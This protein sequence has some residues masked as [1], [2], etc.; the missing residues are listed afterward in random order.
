ML[1]VVR[2]SS[3]E[4]RSETRLIVSCTRLPKTSPCE[5]RLAA[6][7]SA[8]ASP[9]ITPVVCSWQDFV[10]ETIVTGPSGMANYRVQ[11]LV[12]GV[13]IIVP[14]ALECITSYVLYEQEDWFEDEIKFV[15][16]L[17]TYGE[18]VIDIGANFGVYTLAM[19]K[20]VGSSGAVWAFEP[21]SDVAD[22]LEQS[23]ALNDFR[24]AKVVRCAVSSSTGVAQFSTS[25]H[26]ELNAIV[27]RDSIEAAGIGRTDTVQTI[28]LDD[29]LDRFGWRDISFLKIDG[30]HRDTD[31][32]T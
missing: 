21:A 29:A 32:P 13:K 6:A 2:V 26:S 19:A 14:D 15:R 23:I 1:M 9:R 10:E 11:Q 30:A 4:P 27:H 25:S 12:D 5:S 31:S 20:L 8:K 3:F 18:T 7:S 22:F 16:Q 17:L 28:S 24:H